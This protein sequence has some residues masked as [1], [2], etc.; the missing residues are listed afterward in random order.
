M[1][2]FSRDEDEECEE[3]ENVKKAEPYVFDPREFFSRE[4]EENLSTG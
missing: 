1:I 4:T 3:S 2:Y